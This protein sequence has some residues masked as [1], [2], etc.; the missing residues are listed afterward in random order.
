[1]AV[2]RRE[3]IAV[4]ANGFSE[5][6]VA[7]PGA[8]AIRLPVV[9]WFLGHEENPWDLRLGK[10]WGRHVHFKGVAAIS[11]IAKTRAVS[12]RVATAE[13]IEIIPTP[14]DPL[15]TL[16]MTSRRSPQADGPIV[17][18]FFG[19]TTLHKGMQLLPELVRRV[20]QNV[21]TWSVFSDEPDARELA[22]MGASWRELHEF[23]REWVTVKPYAADVRD[24]FAP[25]DVVLTMSTAEAFGRTVAEAML[26]GIPVVA[27][28]IPAHRSLIGDN[29]AGIL[30]PAG[31]LDSAAAAIRQLALDATLREQMSSAGRAR[32]AAFDPEVISAR[33]S[34]LYMAPR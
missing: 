21:A 29:E 19:G 34:E 15:D 24:A 2:H 1:M 7:A 32:A 10:V 20:G 18:G 6:H 14:I 17:V 11:D 25:C 5:L 33:F 16:V 23:G 13:A 27:T 31:D 30:F 22:V 8:L 26:N 28:D 9:V 3:L 4:H 12:A